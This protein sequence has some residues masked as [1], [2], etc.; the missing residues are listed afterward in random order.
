MEMTGQDFPTAASSVTGP[1]VFRKSN[2]RTFPLQRPQKMELQ[3]LLLQQ[4]DHAGHGVE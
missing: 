3:S 4:H 1:D 2:T